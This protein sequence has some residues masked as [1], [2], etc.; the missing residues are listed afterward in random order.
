VSFA[1]ILVFV[2]SGGEIW[3]A[4]S[5]WEVRVRVGAPGKAKDPFSA[6]LEALR[7]QLRSGRLV[8]GEP[9]TITDLAHD[10]GLSA[11]P[12]REAL[13]RLA[14]EHL[15]EDRRGRG[16]FAPRLDA[17]DLVEL[18]GLRCLYLNAALAAYS[19]AGLPSADASDPAAAPDAQLAQLL[20]WIVA[21]AGNR[22][23]FDA[24]RQVGER[25][26]SC[27]R[28]EA[29][30]FDLV[31]EVAALRALLADRGKLA[32]GLYRLHD[33]RRRRA[34]ELIRAMRAGENIASL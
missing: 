12:V 24:Y 15:I 8:S 3:R 7:E 16:Y 5:L 34:P 2:E 31:H 33:E 21:R 23:L 26:A 13:S 6:A 20:D 19:E 17:S 22:A 18:Y 30:V 32:A 29:Q 10:L 9:L 14:G 11:T 4:I 28:V 25:L 1:T 27:V